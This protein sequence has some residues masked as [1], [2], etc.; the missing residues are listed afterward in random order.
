VSQPTTGILLNSTKPAPPDGNQNV[1]PQSDGLVPLQAVSFY[2]QA[3]TDSLLGVVKPDNKT[4][5]VAA[6]GT[7]SAETAGA[8]N[9]I[10]AV[11]QQLYVYGD[12]TGT[13]N[14][15]IVVQT[16]TPNI[17]E[18]SKVVFIAL[19]ANTGPSTLTIDSSP[20]SM[21]P[22]TKEGTEPLTGG[23][24]DAGQ[25]IETV[26]DGTNF[27]IVGGGNGSIGAGGGGGG[28]GSGLGD[29]IPAGA[30]DGVN[31]TF[32]VPWDTS[33]GG[34]TSPSV[35]RGTA[36]LPYTTTPLE[37]AW[38]AGTIEGDFAVIM[39]GMGYAL[40]STP[41]G[42][43]LT[44]NSGGSFIAGGV[45]TKLL[46]ATD[47][48]TGSVTLDFGGGFGVISIVTFVGATSGIRE[49]QEQ[50]TT[51]FTNPVTLTTSSAVSPTDVALYFGAN[52]SNTVGAGHNPPT[53][54]QGT[55]DS[56]A[57]QIGAFGTAAAL[58]VANPS[59]AGSYATVFTY[60]GIGGPGPS[61]YQCVVIV[62]GASPG[63]GTAGS[64]VQGNLYLNGVLQDPLKADP[65]YTIVG[66]TIT[67]ANPP[68]ASP[69]PDT[70]LW[71]YLSGSVGPPGP[72]GG[73]ITTLV[74]DVTAGPGEGTATA[75][76][77]S[78]GV[79]PGSYTTADITVDAKGRITAAANGSGGG[80]S[81]TVTSV[82][83]TVP[84]RQSVS[85]SPVTGAG[86]LTISDDTQN[87]GT[88]FAGPANPA[89][90][91][92]TPTFR[93]IVATD[94]PASAQT[95]VISIVIDGAGSVPT[96]GA[97]A[98]TPPMPYSGTITGWTMLADQ[99]GSA[100]ITVSKGTYSAFPT[101]SSIDASAPP[102]LSSAQK[103]TSTTL[104][105][106]TTS[107]NAGD[108]FGFNLDSISTCTR[109]ELSLQV[110]KS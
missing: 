40:V 89:S 71:V 42:W 108:I 30:I 60:N 43:T 49:V 103:A 94:L 9:L 46:D 73:G 57:V 7:M 78:S 55:I 98:P 34:G 106:W 16:P 37:V 53:I 44:G 33:G 61:N 110:T 87:E 79:T 88:F 83:L 66:N 38:P 15:Y 81:G 59:Q 90:P 75:T 74:G 100:Q 19:N 35:F 21:S 47:I 58:Y 22:I 52:S 99:S 72:A 39:F 6:D 12:D 10:T 82:G 28:S 62:K 80:G 102:V 23:E 27:Q 65:D 68:V 105:G 77:A 64:N 18:G 85:G 31:V 1:K 67:M 3:A 104:T 45:L 107:F 56:F 101:L 84:S 8:D 4:L 14:A 63:G 109:I 70:L 51:G 41:S 95:G 69:S 26:F 24:I 54:N 20:V 92:A 32:T 25:I 97:K 29:V 17:V 11:Q 5:V 91:A 93:A 96:T 50:F 36:T 48:A 76:L 2:P 13:A 86:T